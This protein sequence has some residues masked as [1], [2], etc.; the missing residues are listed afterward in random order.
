MLSTVFVPL[1]SSLVC[2]F[3]V[4]HVLCVRISFILLL[5]IE[6][7]FWKGLDGF[8][9][10]N[11]M[12]NMNAATPSMSVRSSQSLAMGTGLTRSPPM[13]QQNPMSPQGHSMM[14]G[15]GGMN[16]MGQGQGMMQSHMQ[17][18][19][20]PMMMSGP[21]MM[22]MQQQP[23]QSLSGGGMYQQQPNI[24][25]MTP[26]GGGMMGMQGTPQGMGM[27]QQQSGMMMSQ[28]NTMPQN[29]NFRS[30]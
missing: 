18:Q 20:Q 13:Q 14:S 6:H 28:S 2:V 5:R 30:F 1:L 29:N 10:A 25:M 3:Y 7:L 8:S 24:G 21:G 17:Q 4:P 26:M 9:K 27:Q 12:A 19:Q 22:V 11:Q 16:M 15:V 23:S